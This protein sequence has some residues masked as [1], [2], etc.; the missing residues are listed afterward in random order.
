MR[1]VFLLMTFLVLSQSAFA[2]EKK[3]SCSD[4]LLE[5]NFHSVNIIKAMADATE[6]AVLAKVAAAEKQKSP[7]LEGGDE[8]GPGSGTGAA[9]AQPTLYSE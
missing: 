1:F 6:A 5:N 3:V 9:G 2:E 7:N 8:P 4:K